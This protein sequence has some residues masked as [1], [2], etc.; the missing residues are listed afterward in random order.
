MAKIQLNEVKGGYNLSQINSNFGKIETQLNDQVLYRSLVGDE[1]NQMAANLDMNGYRIYNLPDPIL[2]HEPATRKYVKDVGGNSE[3]VLRVTDINIPALPDVSVRANKLLAFDEDGL[4]TVAL[5][6]TDSATDLRLDLMGSGGAGLVGF[7]GETVEAVLANAKSLE[8]YAELRAYTGISTTIRILDPNTSGVFQQDISDAVSADNNGTILVDS[9]GRRWKR[10]YSGPI[11]VKWF[12][13]MGTTAA[14]AAAETAAFNSVTG[15]SVYI[16]SGTYKLNAWIPKSNTVYVFAA[17][18]ILTQGSVSLPIVQ[19]ANGAKNIKFSGGTFIGMANSFEGGI[20]I[21]DL[22]GASFRNDITLDGC[23]F[24]TYGGM[25]IIL[26][27]GKGFQIHNCIFRRTAQINIP[28]GGFSYPAIWCSDRQNLAG[29]DESSDIDI[30]GCVFE[31]LYWS[32]IYALGQR[33][34]IRNNKFK[35]TRESTIFI[36]EF[37][38]RVTVTGNIIDGTTM[39]NI[40]ASGVEVGGEFVNVSGNLITNCE[41]FGVSVQDSLFFNVSA[42]HIAFNRIGIGIISS[43]AERPPRYGA[44]KGNTVTNSTQQGM[45]FVKVGPGGTIFDSDFSGNHITTSGGRNMDFSHNIGLVSSNC[46]INQNT[47]ATKTSKIV[48]INFQTLT[49]GSG[50]VMATSDFRPSAIN[51]VC[52]NPG[53]LVRM[54]DGWAALDPSEAIVQQAKSITENGSQL[55]NGFV[56]NLPDIFTAQITSLEFNTTTGLWE[57]VCNVTTNANIPAWATIT[58][59]P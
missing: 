41:A 50:R 57:V 47:A 25:A 48:S 51:V 29:Y 21:T 13:A 7:D 52:V 8:N 37:A 11:N 36:S 14:T 44:I 20:A 6:A 9:L 22:Q 24:D 23:L 18:A 15:S 26:G 35:N 38:S 27:G 53:S 45:Y 16:P 32:G 34:S 19:F 4:P 28:S 56:V 46:A 12:G 54:S 55:G 42:N 17:D 43:L 1:P 39:Q 31:D 30:Q 5:P 10:I 58:L 40:S 2:D 49:A 59:Q 33:I 3:R